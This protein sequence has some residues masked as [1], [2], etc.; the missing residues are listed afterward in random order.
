VDSKTE[1]EGL[2]MIR[3]PLCT[4]DTGKVFA[5]NYYRCEVCRYVF[6][7][8][9]FLPSK[10]E[11]RRI[12]DY[13]QNDPSDLAYINFLSQITGPLQTELALS[14]PNG[15]SPLEGLDFGC[16]PG[17]AIC[18]MLAS[19]QFL[20]SNFDPTYANDSSLLERNWDFIV[21][22]EVFEHLHTPSE[23]IKMLIEVLNPGGVLAI[24]TLMIT[25]KLIQAPDQFLKWFYRNDPTHVGFFHKDSFEYLA[26]TYNL[27]LR[28]WN[29]R[30]VTL[31]KKLEEV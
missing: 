8:R 31:R 5:D 17:P 16:G 28:I 15:S 12:Y 21:S 20:V 9:D 1:V 2:K 18:E 30:C 4:D 6:L 14:F 19:N 23:N 25:D 26:K 29:D 24:M 10:E 13:H 27:E 11:E 3:C 7:D 22:T